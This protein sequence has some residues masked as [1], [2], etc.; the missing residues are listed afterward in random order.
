M[1]V[2]LTPRLKAVAEYVRPGGKITDVG[3]DHGYLICYLVGNGIC[4]GGVAGDVRPGPL[5]QARQ[6]VAACGLER[7]IQLRLSDGLR[8][9]EPEEA[10]DIVIAGMGG[11]L[12]CEILSAVQWV[13]DEKKHFVFQPMTH[14]EMLRSFLCENG[15]V[16]NRECVVREGKRVYCVMDVSYDGCCRKPGGPYLYLGEIKELGHPDVREYL[17]HMI[18]YLSNKLLGEETSEIRDAV[19]ELKKIYDNGKEHL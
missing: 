13:R 8:A 17:L 5:E 16:I 3:T 19:K 11:E 7:K 12:I 2:K 14:P 4:T 15:F 18:H 9:V 6:S 10:D 1:N